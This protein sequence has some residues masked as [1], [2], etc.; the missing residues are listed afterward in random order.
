MNQPPNLLTVIAVNMSTFYQG[1]YQKKELP[2]MSSLE[3]KKKKKSFFQYLIP[4]S[5]LPVLIFLTLKTD[6]SGI[7]IL[8]NT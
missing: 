8:F 4:R 1:D 2:P 3:K 6:L 5:Y 7:Q